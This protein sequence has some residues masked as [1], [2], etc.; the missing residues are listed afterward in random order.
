MAVVRGCALP[1]NLLYDVENNIWY[2]NGKPQYSGIQRTLGPGDRFLCR[3]PGG[4]GLGAPAHRDPKRVA[5]DIENGLITADY[6]A[7]HHGYDDG[8]GA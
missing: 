7:R 6:A 8:E 1:D 2:V 3:M 4:G 5:R